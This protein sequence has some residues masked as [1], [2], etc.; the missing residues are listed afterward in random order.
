M[1]FGLMG[2]CQQADG[3]QLSAR[4][5][6]RRVHQQCRSLLSGTSTGQSARKGCSARPLE[7][8]SDLFQHAGAADKRVNFN[9]RT[10]SGKT[11]TP[12]PEPSM[13]TERTRLPGM[14]AQGRSVRIDANIPQTMAIGDGGSQ[15]M[16]DLRKQFG[17]RPAENLGWGDLHG[18]V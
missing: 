13:P 4:Q 1:P 18:P 5:R 9:A 6:D 11:P 17:E 15:T 3:H 10:R 8:S 7:P 16:Q 14:D 2:F 12:A